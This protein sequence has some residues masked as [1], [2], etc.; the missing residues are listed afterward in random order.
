MYS[1][2]NISQQEMSEKFSILD[3]NVFDQFE[4]IDF[5]KGLLAEWQVLLY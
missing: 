4:R 2:L 5:V 1:I 3:K